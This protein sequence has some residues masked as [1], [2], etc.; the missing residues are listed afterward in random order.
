MRTREP[1]APKYLRV[2]PSSSKST[3]WS[4]PEEDEDED[5]DDD[6]GS[7]VSVACTPYLGTHVPPTRSNH[8]L[9]FMSRTTHTVAGVTKLSHSASR[10]ITLLPFQPPTLEPSRFP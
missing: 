7:P 9:E 1:S 8:R 4:L 5:E 10:T 3:Y 6:D 2:P